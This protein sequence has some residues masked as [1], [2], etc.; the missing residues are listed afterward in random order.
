[1]SWALASASAST[2]AV[3]IVALV[4]QAFAIDIVIAQ[5][6]SATEPIDYLNQAAC[7]T[8]LIRTGNEH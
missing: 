3:P 1:M 5:T 2:S 4:N 6:G 7:I 8:Y